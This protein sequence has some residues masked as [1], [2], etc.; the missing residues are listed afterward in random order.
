MS[1]AVW[2]AFATGSTPRAQ[3]A[4]IVAHENASLRMA[5]A[6][7]PD[8]SAPTDT[9]FRGTHEIYFND[10]PIEI[11]HVP[12]ATSESRSDVPRSMMACTSARPWSPVA[13]LSTNDLS[14][15][16]TSTGKRRR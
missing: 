6:H 5:A 1:A 16:R 13:T 14:I 11:I 3:H 8:G 10:E 7:V 2:A 9:F 15:F 12:S 4:A